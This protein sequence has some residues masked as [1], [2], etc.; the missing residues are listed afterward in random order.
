MYK[1]ILLPTDGSKSALKAAENAMWT[2]AQS[3]AEIIALHV[4]DM[5]LFA[6]LPTEGSIKGV[7][8]MLINEGKKAFEEIVDMSIKCR[9]KQGKDIKIAFVTREG[10]PADTILK[11]VE[12]QGVDLVIMGTSGK[13]GMNRFLLGSV[14]ENVVRSSKSPVLVVR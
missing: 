8:E 1:K 6:G 7:K 12:D 5:S 9:E 13:H 14:A 11:V 10:H 4:I 3:G 2:A